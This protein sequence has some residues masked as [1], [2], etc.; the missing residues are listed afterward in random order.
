MMVRVVSRLL[1]SGTET[2]DTMIFV[3]SVD[4]SIRPVKNEILGYAIEDLPSQ[5]RCP[6]VVTPH[7]K[8]EG[9]LD[10]GACDESGTV[11]WVDLY[12]RSLRPGELFS[13]KDTRDGETE[14]FTYR[15]VAVTQIS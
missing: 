1:D 4:E 13:R 5:D 14:E 9:M 10:W 2:Q 12:S 6:F 8:G 11:T 15:I 7:G 3:S